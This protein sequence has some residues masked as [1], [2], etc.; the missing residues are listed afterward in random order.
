MAK[1]TDVFVATEENPMDVFGLGANMVKALRYW[2]QAV[3]LTEESVT[4]KR[5]QT[6]T[7]L[8]NLVYKHDPY[9]EERGML[10][11][12]QYRI[13]SNKNLETAMVFFL[14]RIFNAGVHTK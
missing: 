9:F 4:G 12:L 2:L 13:A 3:G 10:C 6:F 8:G 11:L 14:Q 5:I 7:P 1:T